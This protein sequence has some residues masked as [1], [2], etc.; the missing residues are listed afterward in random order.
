M[1]PSS[2]HKT[3]QQEKSPQ[4]KMTILATMVSYGPGRNVKKRLGNIGFQEYTRFG[5]EARSGGWMASIF[6]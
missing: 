2:L 5:K 1:L 6:I 4:K 3:S